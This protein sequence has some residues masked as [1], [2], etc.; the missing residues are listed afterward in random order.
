M[1]ENGITYLQLKALEWIE[2]NHL[3]NEYNLYMIGKGCFD[4]IT[5]HVPFML[6]DFVIHY[7]I[8]N[9]QKEE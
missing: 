2:L 1:N 8:A 5:D 7:S 9:A 4:S 3:E 6:I